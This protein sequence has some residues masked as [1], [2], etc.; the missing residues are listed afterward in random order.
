MTIKKDI[1]TIV[2]TLSNGRKKRFY[3]MDIV[4]IIKQYRL[5]D[6]KIDIVLVT[7][8]G[9]TYTIENDENIKEFL[10]VLDA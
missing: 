9:K 5:F 3:L 8:E 7:L 2:F 10:G 4:R 1:K 6:G